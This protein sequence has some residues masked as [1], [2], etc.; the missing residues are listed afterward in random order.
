MSAI[1]RGPRRRP[2]GH[3]GARDRVWYETTMWQP[4]ERIK[5]ELPATAWPSRD[6][7]AE[8]LLFQPITLGPRT[9]TSRT[10]IPAM[11]PWRATEDGFVTPDVIDWYRRFAEG[12]PGRSEEHTSELQS[13]LHLV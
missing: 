5:H 8:A 3:Q 2:P 4:P 10:W 7:A 13:R 9:A 1:I 12:R 11:V 6:Q